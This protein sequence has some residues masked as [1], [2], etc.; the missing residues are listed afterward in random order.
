M[1]EKPRILIVDDDES[2]RRT[3]TLIFDKQ[4]YGVESAATGQEAIAKAQERFF[5]LALLDIKLPDMEGVELLAHLKEMHPDLVAIV[6]TAYGSLET[7]VRALNKGTSAYI[8]KPLNMDKMLATVRQALEKQRL[9]WEKRRAEE[10]FQESRRSIEAV[11]ETIP[12]LIVFTDP[13]G[14]IVL[15]N[16]ACEEL[17]GYK[18]HEVL[19]KTISELFLPTEWIPIVQK[20]FADPYAPEIRAPHENPWITKSGEQRLIEWRCTVLPSP[21]DGRPCVLGT[22]IDITERK[23]AEEQTKAALTEKEVLLREAHHRAK[24]NLQ[25]ITSLINIQAEQTADARIAQSLQELQERAYTMALVYEHLYQAES[26]VQ[27]PMKPYLQ[28]LSAHVFQTFGGGRAIKLSVEVAPIS[29]DAETAMPCGLIVNE[30]VTNALKY[31]FPAGVKETDEVRVEF[32]AEDV[33]YTL[34]VG[35]NGVGLPSGLDWRKPMTMG[36]RLVHF[37]ATHQ[38][39]GKLE[40]DDRQGTAFKVTF[41]R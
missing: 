2:T 34:V 3:L 22:G 29:L 13:G 35:D 4:G 27:I 20:R 23:Q 31:S 28:D 24:N 19:G 18:R 1:N 17:T 39:G 12:S 32:R 33:T 5:N 38:L 11:V 30:L 36:L 10:A 7:A 37:W 41:V 9:V 15:F 8:T 25:A 14:R 26:L 6:V 16:R 21:E 40:V